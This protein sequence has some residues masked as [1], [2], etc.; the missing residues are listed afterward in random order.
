MQP[1]GERRAVED[2][3]SL[4]SMPTCLLNWTGIYSR[5]Q[6]A[7]Q[8][9][10]PRL[11][12]SHVLFAF[13]KCNNSLRIPLRPGVPTQSRIPSSAPF[14]FQNTPATIKPWRQGQE[15]GT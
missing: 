5:K 13:M 3:G 10:H 9:H 1:S 12:I 15:P 7:G 2:P 14:L 4:S 11:T 8:L 6:T